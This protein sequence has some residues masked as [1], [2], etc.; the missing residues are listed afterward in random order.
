MNK[1]PGRRLRT[2]FLAISISLLVMGGL[3]AAT[4]LDARLVRQNTGRVKGPKSENPEH[5]GPGSGNSGQKQKLARLKSEIA[6]YSA[7]RP[8]KMGVFLRLDDGSELDL[9]GTIRLPSASLIKLP[10]AITIYDQVTQGKLRLNDKVVVPEVNPGFGGQIIPPGSEGEVGELVGYMLDESD[11]ASANALIDKVGIDRVNA[12]ASSVGAKGTKLKRKMLDLDAITAGEENVTTPADMV[13]FLK[14]LSNRNILTAA[15]CN[16]IIDRLGRN[17]KKEMIAS[18]DDAK[19]AH[20]SGVMSLPSG[21]AVGD[22]A[23]VKGNRGGLVLAILTADQPSEKEGV[24]TVEEVARMI[25]TALGKQEEQGRAFRGP[26]KWRVCLDPGHQKNPDLGA[27]PV[28]PGSS[29]VKPRVA[30][31]ATGLATGVPEYEFALKLSRKIEGELKKRGVE[32]TMTRELDEVNVSNS[33]RAQIANRAQ[34]DLFLRIHADSSN[35]P[36]VS[37]ISILQPAQNA[38]TEGIYEKSSRAAKALHAAL[39]NGTGRTDRGILSRGDLAGFNW[40]K[41]PSVLIEAGFL[42]NPEEDRLLNSDSYQEKLARD[43]A[44]GVMEYLNSR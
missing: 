5:A 6:R 37:G 8:G 34:A 29:E 43:I 28:G 20:K 31:G 44:S 41:V 25:W 7:T 9:N 15:Y 26:R 3:I 10:I 2:A 17:D 30:G 18:L 40:S 19:V 16:E 27:E 1:P 42:S 11:N 33:E 39:V 36:S 24:Q 38:W 14:K 12:V 13:L 32:V 35:D 21:F 22:A 4:F 23:I